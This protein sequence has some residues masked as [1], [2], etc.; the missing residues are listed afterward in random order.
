MTTTT[1]PNLAHY[2]AAEL[3]NKATY[4]EGLARDYFAWSA[5]YENE[6]EESRLAAEAESAY[7][8]TLLD[9][10]EAREGIAE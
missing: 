10:L 1:N 5:H 6:A 9:E 2:S 7:A 4:A 3:L 8:R